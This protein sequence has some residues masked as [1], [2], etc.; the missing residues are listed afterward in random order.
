[1]YV[2]L[3]IQV[4]GIMNEFQTNW[5][6]FERIHADFYLSQL[7]VK[8]FNSVTLFGRNNNSLSLITD[9]LTS[10]FGAEKE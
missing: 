8:I 1:M 4:E 10:V 9:L 2:R 7:K 6:A 3:Y 5:S